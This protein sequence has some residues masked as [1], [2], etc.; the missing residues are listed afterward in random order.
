MDAYVQHVYADN[1][2]QSPTVAHPNTTSIGV[3]DYPKLVSLLGAGVRRNGTAGLH[4]PD[5]LRG[6]RRRVADPGV[7]GSAVLGRR[8]DDDEAR[9]R[10]DAGDVL[11]AGTRARV[12]PAD[13]LRHADLPRARRAVAPRLAV[14]DLLR[15][16]DAEDEPAA[17]HGG[18][19][20]DH[21]RLDR[22]LPRSRATGARDVAEV[23]H[24]LRREARR[25]PGQLRLRP[26]LPLLGASRERDHAFARSSRRRA[27]PRWAT[28]CAQI[29]GRGTCHAARTG[30]RS[31]SCTR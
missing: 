14:G 24:S 9:R 17:R 19:R 2:S 16:R 1:S 6:V 7:E 29:S 3:A 8:A 22:A 10:D 26:R 30:T 23:R 15:G 13:R 5:R 18:S 20:P 28:S 12:L 11:P 21:G 25:V 27:R 4:A 31:G